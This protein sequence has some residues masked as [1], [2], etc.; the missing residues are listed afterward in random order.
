MGRGWGQAKRII[1]AVEQVEPLR[2]SR[3]R[4]VRRKPP[5]HGEKRVERK[6]ERHII[7]LNRRGGSASVLRTD[8]PLYTARRPPAQLLPANKSSADESLA[9]DPAPVR[10]PFSL[11]S[12][13]RRWS[14]ARR[15]ESIEER[16]LSA[17]QWSPN[18]LLGESVMIIP[19]RN[20]AGRR[21]G[22]A[23]R[24]GEARETLSLSR[25]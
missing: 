20:Y 10:I 13:G 17:S 1:D 16:D 2:R 3:R 5:R 22:A 18:I 24:S 6:E 8:Q 25:Q 15:W 19:D 7:M 21:E 4:P 23:R 12:I 14:R 11:P 9:R